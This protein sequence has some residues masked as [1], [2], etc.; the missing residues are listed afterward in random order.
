MSIAASIV[1]ADLQAHLQKVNNDPATPL[2]VP[3][4]EQCELYTTTPEFLNETWH[5]TQPLFFQLAQLLPNLQQ[6]P[7]P[8]NRFILKLTA[9]YS[10]G[11]VKDLDFALGLDLSA[12][13]FH[14]LILSLLEKATASGNDAEKLASKPSVVLA[15]VRLWLCTDDTGLATKAGDLLLALLKLSKNLPGGLSPVGASTYG[16]GPV[17]KRLFEDKDIYVLFFIFCSL[18]ALP[19]DGE[20][21]LSKKDKTIAQARLLEWLPKVGA[22]DWNTITTSHHPD[23]E[24]R[25]GLREGQGLLH[26]AATQMVDSKDDILMH[27]SLVNF[28]SDLITTVKTVAPSANDSSLSLEFLKQQGLHSQII[29]FH[30]DDNGSFEQTFLHGPASNYISIYASGY[31]ED[32]EKSPEMKVVRDR[33]DLTIKQCKAE[34]LHILASMP[35]TSLIPHRAT[36]LAWDECALLS[37]PI[38]V[39]NADALKTL[40]TIFHGPVETDLVYP[41]PDASSMLAAV[42]ITPTRQQLERSY[43]RLLLSLYLTKN[44]SMFS[45]IIR[46]ADTIAVKDNALASLVVLRAIITANWASTEEDHSDPIL[47]RLQQFPKSGVELILDPTISGGVL[48]YLLKPATTFSALVGGHG[49]A[50]DAAYQVAMAKFEVLKALGERVKQLVPARREVD[51]MIRRRVSQGPWGVNENVGSR[52]GTLEL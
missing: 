34:D 46:H 44:P 9:P 23:V 14:L 33:L 40:A 2:N 25:A 4:L 41:P 11:H 3:L 26:F 49:D 5:Q 52:I 30:V 21:A 39:T 16:R 28:F 18:R 36:G 17:W 51:T 22:L 45:E 35:R 1:L 10:F 15:I 27:I 32:F 42:H 12:K 6:D 29:H 47:I 37:I 13:P 24:K 43:A 31:P 48:P 7:L 8:L 50:E 19:L 38:R 20:I